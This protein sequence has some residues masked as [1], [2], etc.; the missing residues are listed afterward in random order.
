[1]HCSPNF[2]TKKALREAVDAGREVSIFQPGPWGG[3]EPEDGTVTLEGPHYPEAHRWYAR[4]RVEGGRV[5]K[6][7]K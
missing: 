2:R 6:V 5:V 3:N 4:V 7:L 1:M